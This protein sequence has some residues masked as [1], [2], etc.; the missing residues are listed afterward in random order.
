MS[1]NPLNT[2][3]QEDDLP[4]ELT[5]LKQR[6][7]MMGINYSNNIRIDALRKKI[8]DKMNEVPA[9]AGEA[10]AALVAPV[11]PE[12]PAAAPEAPAAEAAPVVVA[13]AKTPSLRNYLLAEATKLV[14]CRI[15][16]MDPKKQD[17][18]GEFF[19]V[20]NEQLG[21]VRQYVPFGEKTDGGYHLKHCIYEM[22]KSREFLHIQ[23][24]THPITKAITTKT[25]YVREFAIEILPDLTPAEIKQLAADQTASGRLDYQD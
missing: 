14:R 21:T 13:V 17:L 8:E 1:T 24:S 19:T 25:R 10:P 7:T 6:A 15:T 5:M 4:D 16:C 2:E 20:A 18:P 11:V 22:L 3:A 9:E 12:A 23:T